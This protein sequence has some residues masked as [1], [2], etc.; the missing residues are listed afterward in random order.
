[1]CSFNSFLITCLLFSASIAKNVTEQS[2]GFPEA[3]EDP[4]LVNKDV[5]V[6][7]EKYNGINNLSR[8]KV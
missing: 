5:S 8:L 2:I 3:E 4:N 1:M 6:V 7:L